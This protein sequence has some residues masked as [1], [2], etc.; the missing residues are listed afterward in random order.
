MKHLCVLAEFLQVLA[1]CL[2]ESQRLTAKTTQETPTI[3]E[4]FLQNFLHT[5]DGRN[6][7][8]PILQLISLMKPCP[9]E[10]L[11]CSFLKPLYR[12]YL[13]ALPREM[14]T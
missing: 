6:H 12:L 9:F 14:V 7:F 4:T 1:N 3:V 5:W 8:D 13:S 10:E 2:R 11:Y